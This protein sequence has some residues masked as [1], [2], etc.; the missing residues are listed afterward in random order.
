MCFSAPASFVA[1][2]LT[3]G[4]GIVTLAKAESGRDVPLAAMPILFSLQQFVEGLLWLTLPVAANGADANVLTLAFLIFAAVLWPVY[5]PF[6]TAL[7]EPK[8]GRRLAMWLVVVVGG[9][10]AVYFIIALSGH[11]PRASILGGHICYEMP[12]KAPPWVAVIYM[13]V[14]CLGFLLSS[15]RS[16]LVLGHIVSVGAIVSYIFYWEAFTSVWC[17]FAA[18]ASIVLHHHFSHRARTRAAARV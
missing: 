2:A 8:K 5:S 18:A 10:V 11:E 12:R 7:V 17:F 6:A 13:I 1:A 15:H 16:I 3:G 9:V 4:I 14:T